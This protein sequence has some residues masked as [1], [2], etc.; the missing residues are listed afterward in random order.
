[1][2]GVPIEHQGGVGIRRQLA[3]LAAFVIGEEQE[4]PLV[5]SFQQDHSRRRASRGRGG[6]EGH[7]IGLRYAR[8]F[9]GAEPAAELLEG[10]CVES[11][12]GKARWLCQIP[13]YALSGKLEV[14][15][16]K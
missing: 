2:D 6:G 16:K 12:L 8:P 11:A 13:V 10:I 5:H 3:S 4:A 9:D 1:M 7:G 15:W 14:P